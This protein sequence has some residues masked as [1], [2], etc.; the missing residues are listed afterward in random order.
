MIPVVRT[1]IINGKEID[2]R[3]KKIKAQGGEAYI[4]E[5]G[6][7]LVAKIFRRGDDDFYLGNLAEQKGAESRLAEHQ[8]KLPAFPVNLP[9][10]V[11]KPKDLVTDKSGLIVGYTMPFIPNADPLLSY[12]DKGFVKK[13]GI[14]NNSVV[15]IFRNLY[16]A[17]RKT[18]SANVVIGDFNDLNVLVSALQKIHLIDSDSFQFAG[19]QSTVFTDRF[20]D[21]LLCVAKDGKVMLMKPHNKESDWYAFAVMLFQSFLYLN[22]YGGV[23]KP[24]DK[25]KKIQ[26]ELRPLHN[27]SVLSPEVIYPKSAIPYKVLPDEVLGFFE[28]LFHKDKRGTFP[29]ILLDNLRWTKCTV[30][31]AE[32]ARNKCPECNQANPNAIKEKVVWRGKVKATRFFTTKGVILFAKAESGMLKWLYFD[33]SKFKRDDGTILTEGKLEPGFRFRIMGRETLFAKGDKLITFGSDSKI[34]E[35]KEIDTCNSLSVFDANE[36]ARYWVDSGGFLS[37]DDTFGPIVIGS[38]LSGE[39]L[40]W[41]GSDFGFGFYRAGNICTGFVFG[42]HKKG[43]IDSI[44]LTLKGQLL[45][46]WTYFGHEVCWF[47]ATVSLGGKLMNICYLIGRDGTILSKEECNKD[48]TN[49]WLSGNIR[50]KA[51][52]GKL[53]FAPTDDGIIRIELDSGTIRVTKEFPDTAPFLDSDSA[54]HIG[55]GEIYVVRR[56]EILSLKIDW[57]F[58]P[59]TD[60]INRV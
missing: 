30:C 36:N 37:R 49:H 56:H 26:H 27:I 47:F 28:N 9:L 3:R 16:E 2:L 48:T 19:F 14:D 17:V 58:L 15:A 1:V 42:A 55:K 34:K 46:A 11:V 12:S 51:A 33:D 52:V 22:P 39:T 18:H 20:V 8:R 50:G 24:Q 13:S 21:P 5:L 4:Y 59:R 43:L 29:S 38:V 44:K 23:Y 60:A 54:L 45:D 57:C 31:G 7:N 32:H 25:T 6:S 53:I 40:F 10:E 41:T 35:V